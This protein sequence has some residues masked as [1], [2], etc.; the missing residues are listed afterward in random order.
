V[1][2]LRSLFAWE[3]F[4]PVFAHENTFVGTPGVHSVRG[5]HWAG[6]VSVPVSV[7]GTLLPHITCASCFVLDGDDGHG[8]PLGSSEFGFYVFL[9]NINHLGFCGGTW[10]I[11]HSFVSQQRWSRFIGVD[12]EDG[13][14]GNPHHQHSEW[15]G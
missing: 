9:I 12:R 6:P 13:S 5:V 3:Q 11:I 1:F 7:P 4:I 8:Q 2:V 14:Q 15:W 10:H